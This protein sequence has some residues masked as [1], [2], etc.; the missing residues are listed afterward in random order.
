MGNPDEN[1]ASS[2]NPLVVFT[3][4]I[5]VDGSESMLYTLPMNIN[6]YVSFLINMLDIFVEK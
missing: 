5:C 1:V 4:Y 3:I 6:E 2:S